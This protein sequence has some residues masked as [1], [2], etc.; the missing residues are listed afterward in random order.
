MVDLADRPDLLD[1][2]ARHER[3]V[4]RTPVAYIPIHGVAHDIIA[5]ISLVELYEDS[6]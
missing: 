3:A 2:H 6:L 5:V 4:E 1:G